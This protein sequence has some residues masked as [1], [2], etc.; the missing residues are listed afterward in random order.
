VEVTVGVGGGVMVGVSD[1]VKLLELE[2][3]SVGD[4]EAEVSW[5]N[6][7]DVDMLGEVVLVRYIRGTRAASVRLSTMTLSTK[8]IAGV[9]QVIFKIELKRPEKV[10]GSS[11]LSRTIGY[12][13]PSYRIANYI[14]LNS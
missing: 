2:R 11:I 3:S 12:W 1:N 4:F 10:K 7:S 5:D 13:K 9:R 14:S 8:I 6:D